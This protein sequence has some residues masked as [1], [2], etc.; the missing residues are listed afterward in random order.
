MKKQL[1]LTGVPLPARKP[2]VLDGEPGVEFEVNDAPWPTPAGGKWA[3]CPREL[4][5]K[6][7]WRLAA[8]RKVGA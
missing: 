5:L 7:K 4:T 2:L 1:P 6:E 3:P 8:Q